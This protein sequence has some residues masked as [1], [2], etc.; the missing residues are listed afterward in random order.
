MCSDVIYLILIRPVIGEGKPLCSR[1]SSLSPAQ[2]PYSS[3]FDDCSRHCS[4]T[5]QLAHIF[6]A[7]FSRRSLAL[8]L[9]LYGEKNILVVPRQAAWPIQPCTA[10]GLFNSSSNLS[11]IR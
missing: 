1:S 9:S 5:G 7:I 2:M 11:L 8:A 4:I 3:F 6:L 10:S